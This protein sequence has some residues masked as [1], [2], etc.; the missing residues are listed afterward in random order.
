MLTDGRICN[1]FD[2]NYKVIVSKITNLKK[3]KPKLFTWIYQLAPNEVLKVIM[4]DL[5]PK[6]R[7]WRIYVPPMIKLCLGLHLLAGVSYLDLSFGYDVPH[8]TVH[9]YSWQALHAVDA[10]N[11]FTFEQYKVIQPCN[12]GRASKI[13][14]WF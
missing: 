2:V 3:D 9:F 7:K 5:M 1:H 10:S 14:I 12:S 4:A 6:K 11:L 8:N 13:R